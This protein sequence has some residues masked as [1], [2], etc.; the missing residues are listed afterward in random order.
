MSDK[1]TKEEILAAV[2]KWLDTPAKYTGVD[3]YGEGEGMR[4]DQEELREL[5]DIISDIIDYRFCTDYKGWS[6]VKQ[7]PLLS[8]RDFEYQEIPLV[9]KFD[10]G[11]GMEVYGSKEFDYAVE[12]LLI[13]STSMLNSA[14]NLIKRKISCQL[15]LEKQIDKP[16]EK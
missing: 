4:A 13:Y 1:K 3:Y 8:K 6:Y 16:E 15:E 7:Y 2:E 12:S 9:P 5:D 11:C 10:Y 14:Q